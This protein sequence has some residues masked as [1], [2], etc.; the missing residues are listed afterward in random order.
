ML[1]P[2]LLAKSFKEEFPYS[3]SSWLVIGS[4]T[5]PSLSS[6]LRMFPELI[7]TF[8]TWVSYWQ[9]IKFINEYLHYKIQF[10]STCCILF[11]YFRGETFKENQQKGI[12]ILKI[13]LCSQNLSTLVLL[14]LQV[15]TMLPCPPSENP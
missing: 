13:L 1:G 4:P 3:K 15:L 14:E 6:T 2:L 5:T 8:I 10:S 12:F 9:H 7:L 11:R